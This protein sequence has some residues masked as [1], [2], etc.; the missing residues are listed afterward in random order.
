M[1]F[2]FDKFKEKLD[3]SEYIIL[4][5]LTKDKKRFG[6]FYKNK[7]ENNYNQNENPTYNNYNNNYNYNYAYNYQAN[8]QYQTLAT[9]IAFNSASS[10]KEYF[11]FSFD[12]FK[13]F[14]SNH[15]CGN[16]IVIPSFTINLEEEILKGYE[17]PIGNVFELAGI[18]KF[19][20]IRAELYS[21]QYGYL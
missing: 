19:N 1:N 15:S 16:N 13:I 2:N 3:N 21:I 12:S 17:N 11:V 18:K 7:E 4:I 14:Y 8:N 10:E 6:A 20:I 5:I 9:K